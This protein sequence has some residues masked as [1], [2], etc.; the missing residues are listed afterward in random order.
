MPDNY[1]FFEGK[2]KIFIFYIAIKGTDKELLRI[3]K[4]LIDYFMYNKIWR[5]LQEHLHETMYSKKKFSY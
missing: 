3:R 5:C 2:C 1:T 4:A